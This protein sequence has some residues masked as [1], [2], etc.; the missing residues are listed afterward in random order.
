MTVCIAAVCDKGSTCVVA[1]DREITLGGPINVGYEHHERKIDALSGS[2]VAMS[3]GNALVASEVISRTRSDPALTVGAS[4][5]SVAE[6]MRA[7]YI[8]VHMRRA[9]EV[10]LRPRGW[11]LAEFKERGAQGIPVQVYVSID[12]QFWAL[13]LNTEFIVAGVD[14]TGAHISWVHYHGLSG[15]GWLEPFDKIGFTAIGSGGSHATILLSLSGQHRDLPAWDTMYRVFRAK[16]N[17]EVAPGV[18]TATDLAI[19]Q[20][21][22]VKFVSGEILQQ[23]DVVV[24]ESET[25][26]T[27]SKVLQDLYAE[28]TG[29]GGGESK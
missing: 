3:S 25:H 7:V 9:E 26:R 22:G 5:Q 12:Q 4:I 8:D 10:I 29:S 21:D 2:C 11:T 23:L 27:D 20:A 18:G 28:V 19:I 17:A 6:S 15:A 1:A 16:K 13:T 24:R 14:Q